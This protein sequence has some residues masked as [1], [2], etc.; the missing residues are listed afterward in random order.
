MMKG[1]LVA[2]LGYADEDIFWLYLYDISFVHL[3]GTFGHS[4]FISCAHQITP[5]TNYQQH[6]QL[7]INKQNIKS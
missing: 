3:S 2:W 7:I 5:Q 4:L 1:E 6:Y